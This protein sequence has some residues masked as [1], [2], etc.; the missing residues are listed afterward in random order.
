MCYAESKHWP[1]HA[2]DGEDEDDQND[3]GEEEEEEE[4]EPDASTAEDEAYMQHLT[5]EAAKLAVR[6]LTR[7]P[8][9]CLS[10]CCLLVVLSR[11]APRIAH[12]AIDEFQSRGS[13]VAE[14]GYSS[15]KDV[16]LDQTSSSLQSI[17]GS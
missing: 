17:Q 16:R 6:S 3:V 11:G 15:C 8:M 2:E 5:H 10:G 1:S 14:A 9:A 7:D 13:S 12:R 4:E